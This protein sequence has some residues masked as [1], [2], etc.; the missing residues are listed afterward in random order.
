MTRRAISPA[1]L[2]AARLDYISHDDTLDVVAKRHGIG[3]RKVATLSKQQ[4]WPAQR[5]AQESAL[6]ASKLGQAAE[7]HTATVLRR[8]RELIEPLCDQAGDLIAREMELLRNQPTDGAT[9]QERT[10]LVRH[11]TEVLDKLRDLV[12]PGEGGG[13]GEGAVTLIIAPAPEPAPNAPSPR[14]LPAPQAMGG[15][16]QSD[17]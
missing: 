15:E 11:L 6:Q 2:E 4:G 17:G 9:W 8:W 5:K 16:G 13:D 14:L 7:R 3:M 12:Q 1:I 10:V